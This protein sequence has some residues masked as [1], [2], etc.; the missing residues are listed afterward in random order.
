[1]RITNNVIPALPSSSSVAWGLLII[2]YICCNSSAL[3]SSA[4]W[5]FHGQ[6]LLK[7]CH[8]HANAWINRRFDV[9]ISLPLLT[10]SLTFSYQETLSS[11]LALVGSRYLSYLV[12]NDTSITQVCLCHLLPWIHHILAL[13]ID[14]HLQLSMCLHLHDLCEQYAQRIPIFVPITRWCWFC[15][16][17]WIGNFHYHLDFSMLFYDILG[18]SGEKNQL[19][20]NY[21]LVILAFGGS[22]TRLIGGK[23]NTEITEFYL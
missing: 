10:R 13:Q 5:F 18:S 12:S 9:T 21:F 23:A 7:W 8:N 20:N 16:Y 11:L 22:T 6:R 1:M 2:D 14:V 4:D 17:Y 3:F 15:F 19:V